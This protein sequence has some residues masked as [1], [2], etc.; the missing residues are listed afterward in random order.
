VGL[1]LGGG[2]VGLA[3]ALTSGGPD[4]GAESDATFACAAIE[5]SDIPSD[6][7]DVPFSLIRRWAGASEL[8]AAAAE[9]DS[10]YESLAHEFNGVSLGIRSFDFEQ[11]DEAAEKAKDLCADL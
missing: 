8:A 2:G 4:S 3:W 6:P 10:S 7:E 11:V 9:A 5:D 1:L